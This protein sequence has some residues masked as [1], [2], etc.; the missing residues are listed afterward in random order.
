MTSILVDELLTRY[1]APGARGF[2]PTPFMVFFGEV[3]IGICGMGIGENEIVGTVV[4]GAD[5]REVR[6]GAT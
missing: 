4:G 2:D 3:R 5:G 6:F 1:V